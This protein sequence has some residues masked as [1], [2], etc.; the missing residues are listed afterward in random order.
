MKE[1]I[2]KLKCLFIGFHRVHIKG[3]DEIPL[4]LYIHGYIS[5]DRVCRERKLK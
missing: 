4:S 2:V 3:D 1:A 5:F